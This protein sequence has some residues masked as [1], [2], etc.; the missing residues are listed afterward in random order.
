M[1]G[2]MVGPVEGDEA[3]VGVALGGLAEEVDAVD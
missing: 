3:C 1:G 2:G